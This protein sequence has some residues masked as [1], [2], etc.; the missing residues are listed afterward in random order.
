M[1]KFARF[2]REQST[3]TYIMD[4]LGKI[5]F[6]WSNRRVYLIVVEIVSQYLF[7]NLESMLCL[8]FCHFN[9]WYFEKI[10]QNVLFQLTGNWTQIEVPSPAYPSDHI[11]VKY[12]TSHILMWSVSIVMWSKWICEYPCYSVVSYDIMNF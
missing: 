3:H 8:E 7:S 12:Y 2:V 6:T 1:F 11:F 4:G 10:L 9:S 5:E